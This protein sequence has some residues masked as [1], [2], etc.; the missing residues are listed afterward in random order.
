MVFFINFI[1]QKHRERASDN[2]CNIETIIKVDLQGFH[3][4]PFI[5]RSCEIELILIL[6]I[7]DYDLL[8]LENERTS[9]LAV[10]L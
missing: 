3:F 2:N 10:K 9:L 6:F 7:G 5:L 1:T 4:G 8:Y